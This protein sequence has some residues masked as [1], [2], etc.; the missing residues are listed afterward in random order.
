MTTSAEVELKG[1]VFGLVLVPLVK[2]MSARLG[3]QSLASL[4]YLVENGQPYVG[5][6]PLAR[7]PAGC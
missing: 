5:A 3:A 6:E 2:L 4:K 1:G 7:A